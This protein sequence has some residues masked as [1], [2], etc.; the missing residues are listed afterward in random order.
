MF[1][2]ADSDWSLAEAAHLLNRAG[3]GGGPVEIERV[4]AMGRK[5]AVEWLVEPDEVTELPE[6][7]RPEATRERLEALAARQRELRERIAGLD[8][9]AAD[10]ARR[11]SNQAL[12]REQR[13]RLAAAQGW[14]FRRMLRTGAPL[15][16]KMVLFWHD[17]FPSSFQKVRDPV[18]LMRQNGRFREHALGSFHELTREML[19]DPALLLYL[20][21]Q[22]S[23]R[24]R[25]NEN[26]ARELLE[27]FTLGEGAYDERDV[28][29]AA[30]A[31]TGL[32]VDRARGRVN[33]QR[34]QWD[35]GRKTILGRSAPFDGPMLADHL[36]SLEGPSRFLA[37]K[38]LA[39]FVCDSP[40]PALTETMA[41][42]LRAHGHR[43][44]PALREL[45]LSRE[46]NDP[47]WVGD[48]IKSPLQFLVQMLKELEIAEPPPG[49]ALS[50][51]QQL[52]QVLFQP[53]NVAGWDWGQSWINT[54]T[55]LA[56]YN[57]AGFLTRGAAGPPTGTA[58]AAAR[59]AAARWPGPDYVA[60][61]PHARREDPERLV[62]LLIQRFFHREPPALARESFVAYARSKSAEGLGHRDLAELC[63]LMLSTP[64]Y[65]LC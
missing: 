6:W 23:R 43:V 16:E 17:H 20:D 9:A 29:E 10:R 12:Q 38:L 42:L 52:G 14:W 28:R 7:A 50:G 62:D 30:R 39:Y 5:G 44:G 40:P 4:H 53:P 51:Q 64:H 55:L 3:F 37:G 27:L 24:D 11:E 56:R 1:T 58:G 41:A 26:L 15:R 8:A 2:P 19:R 32:R 35:A 57:L 36:F 46:F 31:L 59:Q 48:Q 49:F 25:P 65:Q 18:L 47:G 21:A 61:A 13:A 45:F 60:I 33:F 34:R 22:N 54:Q 63:H